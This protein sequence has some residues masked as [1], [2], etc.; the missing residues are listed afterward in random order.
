MKEFFCVIF[1]SLLLTTQVWAGPCHRL[2]E[3]INPVYVRGYEGINSALTV[4]GEYEYGT[5]LANDLIVIFKDCAESKDSNPKIRRILDNAIHEWEEIKSLYSEYIKSTNASTAKAVE[6]AVKES[7]SQVVSSLFFGLVD[8]NRLAGLLREKLGTASHN[9]QTVIDSVNDELIDSSS[10]NNAIQ[11]SLQGEKGT[12][13]PLAEGTSTRMFLPEQFDLYWSPSQSNI[14]YV[15]HSPI[16]DSKI[17]LGE[18]VHAE[19]R[20]SD[21]AIILFDNT[22]RGI[23]LGARVNT[24]LQEKMFLIDKLLV[25]RTEN[26]EAIDG[27]SFELIIR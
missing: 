4:D 1:F 13:F 17:F 21:H 25:I 8:K 23:D 5:K 2:A 14:L 10:S 12:V 7:E 27:F 3:D 9:I 18:N 6:G 16:Y 26:K 11:Q 22:G 20:R 24:L 15:F 19:Y